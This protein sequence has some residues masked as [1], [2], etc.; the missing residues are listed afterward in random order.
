MNTGD[1]VSDFELKD[2]TGTPRRL[3]SLLENGPVVLFF[4]PIASSGGCT[5]EACHFRD[6]A[7][8]FAAL[9]AQPVGISGDG[10]TAQS[11]F[12]SAHSLGYPLLS[13]TGK[14]VAKE[15]GAK[16]W[17]LPGGLQTKRMTFVI[18]QDRRII[19]VI[20]SETK[21]DMHADDALAALKKHQAAA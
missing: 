19:E 10:V 18:G 21:F 9:G 2:E 7:A 5:Q 20:A 16:R 17:W 6:L 14:K 12:A 13:D 4:Y 1:Q 8:E 3:S 11:T 15:L